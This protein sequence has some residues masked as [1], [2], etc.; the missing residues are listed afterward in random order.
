MKASRII[1]AISLLPLICSANNILTTDLLQTLPL[2]DESSDF[3]ATK[4]VEF[5]QAAVSSGTDAS[6]ISKI[7]LAYFTSSNCTGSKAGSGF[8]TTPDGTSF[9][10]SVGTPFGLVASSAWQVGN[11]K[12][13]IA[14]MTTVQ[15][16]AVTFKSTNSN[17]P[18][19]AFTDASS[20]V[21][22]YACVPVTCTAGPAGE[23]TSG[24]GTQSFTLKTTAAIGDPA[25]GGVIGCQNT[26]TSFNLFNIVVSVSDNSTGQAW[27]GSGTTTNA[28]STTDGSSNTAM[29]LSCLTGPGGE[30]GCPQNISA[31]TYAAGNCSTYSAAGGFTSG[32]FLPSG[33]VT[34][35]QLNCIYNNRTAINAG[36]SA[37]GGSA[38]TSRANYWSSTE[39]SSTNA[40]AMSFFT[41]T[42]SSPTKS[43]SFR[44]RCAQAF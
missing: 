21:I 28:T 2:S 12:L 3:T 14:D 16:I 39:S 26:G 35:S 29:I 37:A 42:L 6:S 18:Q 8:Y 32:W 34:N 44:V 1:L 36:A 13:S 11:T 17:T 7:T 4:M 33:G 30:A 22:S 19:A 5:Q 15:S 10:I 24:S 27:G 31:S 9:P 23:C 40:G 20:H 41:G 25:D 43:N 38:F